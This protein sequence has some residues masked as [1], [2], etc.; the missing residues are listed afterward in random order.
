MMGVSSITDSDISNN[1]EDESQLD[2]RIQ[3]ELEC[4]NNATNEINK[5][6][7]ELD[8]ARAR[9]RQTLSDSSSTLNSLLKKH[10]KSIEKSK[11]YYHKLG[12]AKKTQGEAQR[13]VVQFRRASSFYK[14]AKETISLA[15]QR[16]DDEGVQFDEAWQ[17]ML[18]HST[19][20]MMD[21]EK[22]KVRSELEHHRKSQAYQELEKQVHKLGRSHKRSI[23]T[24]KPYYDLKTQLE[25]QLQQQKQ[26]VEDLQQ[27]VGVAKNNYRHAMSNL[28]KISEEIHEMRKLPILPPREPGVGCDSEELFPLEINLEKH[29]NFDVSESEDTESVS[30]DADSLWSTDSES[31]TQLAQLDDVSIHSTEYDS[32]ICSPKSLS[33]ERAFTDQLVLSEA[34]DPL[35]LAPN[36]N[37]DE[38]YTQS[39]SPDPA[40][41]SQAST[42]TIICESD[43][44]DEDEELTRSRSSTM[45]ES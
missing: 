39:Q 37:V 26:N 28:E 23:A 20:K 17:E 24:A 5:L 27:A 21:A 44:E 45:K 43:R 25:L 36:L 22:E 14:A 40:L 6:E 16:L 2:P 12:L 42:D 19:I 1:T 41:E 4:M 10:K 18:N 9:F 35:A 38:L 34:G 29:L 15:E 13:A 32:A 8:E 31:L 3:V 7:K 33:L 11:T 30:T